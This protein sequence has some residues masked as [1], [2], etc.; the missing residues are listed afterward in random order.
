M[1]ILENA[2]KL[3]IDTDSGEISIAENDRGDWRITHQEP[4]NCVLKGFNEENILH[5]AFTPMQDMKS[6]V[7][8]LHQS[9]AGPIEMADRMCHWE[10]ETDTV[11]EILAELELSNAKRSIHSISEDFRDQMNIIREG[12]SNAYLLMVEAFG[13]DHRTARGEV[14]WFNNMKSWITNSQNPGTMADTYHAMEKEG[15]K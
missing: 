10:D 4:Y 3:A 11:N 13:N 15:E 12:I 8:V 2:L 7:A 6:S 14:Y 1:N 5:V 9:C